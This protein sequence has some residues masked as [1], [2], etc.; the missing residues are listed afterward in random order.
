LLAPYPEFPVGSAS[1]S[2]GV[3]EQNANVGSSY[4]HSL[5]VRL[6]KRLSHG[7]NIIGT[8]IHSKLIEQDSWLN[9]TDPRPEKR[10]SP[11]DHPNRFVTAIG[12]DLPIGKGKMLNLQSRWANMIFGGWGLN[13]IYSYQTGAPINWLNGSTTTPGDY[14]YFGGNLALNNREVS[15]PTAV[16]FNKS[17]FDTLAADQFQYHIRTFSTTFPNLRQD[18]IN[19]FD[20]SVRKRIDINE[21]TYFQIRFEAFNILNH[22]T[23]SAPN[24]TVTN[25]SFGVI[26]TQANR[27]RQIQLGARFVF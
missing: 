11:F 20:S 5:N 14:V 13:G 4:F 24:A 2:T 26:T 1:G 8:Y 6:E 7:V 25:G 27:P 22:P 9:D 16:A 23:F 3:L 10:I 12:Y 21:K 18:G 17:L 15:S 19:N